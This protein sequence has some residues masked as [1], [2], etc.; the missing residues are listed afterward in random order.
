MPTSVQILNVGYD[1]VGLGPVS[2]TN[3]IKKQID[4]GQQIPTSRVV[5]W[6]ISPSGGYILMGTGLTTVPT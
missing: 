6:V 2:P 5:N 4:H 1:S 3:Q